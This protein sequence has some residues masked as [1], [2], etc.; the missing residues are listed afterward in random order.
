MYLL[1]LTTFT[2]RS[3]EGNPHLLCTA[4]SCVNK[5]DGG[6][7]KKSIIVPIVASIASIAVLVVALALFFVFRKK[8]SSK[9]EGINK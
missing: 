4:D 8:K 2:F 6:H 5:G 3:V 9:P 7:K 1:S